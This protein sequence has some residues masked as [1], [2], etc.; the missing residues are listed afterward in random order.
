MRQAGRYLPEYRAVRAKRETFLEL[1]LDPELAA[2]VT[3]Q[4]VRRFGPD[5]AI[6]FSDILV[7]PFLLGRDVRFAD[8]TGPVLNAIEGVGELGPLPARMNASGIAPVYETIARVRAALP[9]EV[10]LIGFAGAPWTVA[11]YMVEGGSSRDYL[12]T[13]RWLYADP[14]GFSALI[15]VL[16]EATIAHLDA[17]IRA[18][19][20]V[21]KL[22]DSWAGVLA[23]R[24][25]ERWCIA[26]TRRI[27]DELHRRHPGVPVIGFPRGAG[28]GYAEFVR[29]SGVDAVAID[30]TV[31]PVWAARV[32][33]PLVPVQGNLDPGGPGCGRRGHGRRG[34][35]DHPRPVTRRAC[36][37]SGPRGLARHAT[38]SRR[39]AGGAAQVGERSREPRMAEFYPWIK[40]AHVISVMAWMAGMLYLPR[41]FVYHADAAPGSELSETLKLMEHRLLRLIIN[42]A[43]L[44]SFLFGLWMLLLD[45]VLL[46]QPWMWVQAAG[47]GG[48]DGGARRAGALAPVLRT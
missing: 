14:E 41:L 38:G 13:R 15:D 30:T 35:R 40:A 39:G 9:G 16:I 27:V 10:A 5:A 43:M 25:F 2:E 23:P 28:S 44:A 20:Q 4:P 45:P 48:P 37:Q 46:E 42:P 8:G 18:G 3:L 1:C 6:V 12:R 32:L 34:A 33:Q 24:A 7:I 11:T 26:P 17:Q 29:G 47:P 36:L 31:S 21:V 19:A 22:F